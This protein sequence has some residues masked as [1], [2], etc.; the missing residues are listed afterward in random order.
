[1]DIAR[2]L[3]ILIV[4]GVPGI[5]FGGLVYAW[6]HS[7]VAV[8]IWEIVMVIIAVNLALKVTRRTAPEAEGH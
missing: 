4:F 6:F 7:W 8:W 1:M 5:W 2:F 3:G